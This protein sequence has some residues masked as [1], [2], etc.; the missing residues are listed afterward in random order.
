MR[1][2]RHV[3][4]R[5]C[6]VCSRELVISRLT[7][8]GCGTDLTGEF[9]SCEFCALS[10]EDR[11]ALRVFLASRGNMRELER[12]MGVSYPTARARFDALLAR[13]G[14][15]RPAPPA[16]DRVEVLRRLAQGELDVGAALDLLGSEERAS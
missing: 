11:E 15:E 14:M 4:P 7:C 10:H 1:T 13:L 9:R 16:P 12:H 8:E 2:P 5:V 6:P 3:P